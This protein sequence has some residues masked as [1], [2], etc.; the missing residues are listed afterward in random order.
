MAQMA[1]GFERDETGRLV[2]GS[3][4]V[5]VKSGFLRTASGALAVSGPSF[6]PGGTTGQVLTK[7]SDAD[8]DY[9]WVTP[10]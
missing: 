9:G 5:E 3:D 1:G 6:P 8:G 4:G 7:L 10:T 2:V